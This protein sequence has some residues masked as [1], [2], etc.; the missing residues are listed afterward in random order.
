M[1]TARQQA[2]MDASDEAARRG[3]D[4]LPGFFAL[5]AL[6]NDRERAG[7]SCREHAV[8]FRRDGRRGLKCGACGEVQK[9]IDPS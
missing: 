5:V 8:G 6:P 4:L 9:W 1:T 2:W 3:E 7:H